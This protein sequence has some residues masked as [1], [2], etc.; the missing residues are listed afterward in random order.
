MDKTLIGIWAGM[1]CRTLDEKGRLSVEELKQATRLESD[2]IYAAI[3]WLARE[4]NICFFDNNEFSVH[5]YHEHY[6]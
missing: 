3:G 6:Y 5:I 2:S 1:I 4:G